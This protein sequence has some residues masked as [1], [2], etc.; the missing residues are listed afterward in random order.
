MR[1]MRTMDG[2]RVRMSLLP[3][4]SLDTCLKRGILRTS[5]SRPRCSLFAALHH[6]ANGTFQ[7]SGDNSRRPACEGKPD[8]A[9]ILSKDRLDPN[10]V[11]WRGAP[12]T[13]HPHLG[14][15]TR[16]Q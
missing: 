6:V 3:K 2:W 11:L 4:A 9:R 15:R 8:I 5:N 16:R 10:A 7:S 12:V 13:P 14:D 1:W